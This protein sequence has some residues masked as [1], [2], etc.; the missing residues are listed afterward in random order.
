MTHTDFDFLYSLWQF[1]E[2]RTAKLFIL[3]IDLPITVKNYLSISNWYY[4]FCLHHNQT[5]R[6]NKLY[7]EALNFCRKYIF[8]SLRA[9]ILYYIKQ[10]EIFN[11]DFISNSLLKIDDFNVL[12][13]H[14]RKNL[15]N[16]IKLILEKEHED[17]FTKEKFDLFLEWQDSLS[18]Y[19]NYLLIVRN[20]AEKYKINSNQEK[21]KKSRSSLGATIIGILGLIFGILGW[22]SCQ[23]KMFNQ[24]S[25]VPVL[26]DGGK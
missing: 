15:Y 1:A 24:N 22:Q 3:N 2:K 11:D 5:E 12:D 14:A 17:L 8:H 10:I 23:N 20:E 19:E 25:N 18:N 13:F 26:I 21:R 4:S 9:E 6:G 7:L 16:E